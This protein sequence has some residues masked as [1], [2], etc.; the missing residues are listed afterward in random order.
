MVCVKIS[1]ST[2]MPVVLIFYNF[3]LGVDLFR[4]IIAEMAY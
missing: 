3:L 4:K 2:L 1:N